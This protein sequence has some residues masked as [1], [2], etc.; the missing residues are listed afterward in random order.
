MMKNHTCDRRFIRRNWKPAPVI[1][2]EL[3]LDEDVSSP[4]FI[5]HPIGEEQ[6]IEYLY[7]LSNFAWRKTSIVPW[8]ICPRSWLTKYCKTHWTERRKKCVFLLFESYIPSCWWIRIEFID[9]LHIAFTWTWCWI[10]FIK[11]ASCSKEEIEDLL[12]RMTYPPKIALVKLFLN[13]ASSCQ[14]VPTSF[15]IP[16]LTNIRLIFL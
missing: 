2:W 4:L 7:P 1:V 3:V 12:L 9:F 16:N 10:C 11:P 13:V 6:M 15:Q 5:K 8:L 14:L